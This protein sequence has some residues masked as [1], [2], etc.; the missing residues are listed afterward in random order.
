M[1]YA[2]AVKIEIKSE[3]S[4]P[5]LC[6]DGQEYFDKADEKNTTFADSEESTNSSTNEEGLAT[7]LDK[8]E[9]RFRGFARLL[10]VAQTAL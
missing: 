1:S 9:N 7:K 5:L 4:P 6:E 3:Y 10:V 2:H 8:S